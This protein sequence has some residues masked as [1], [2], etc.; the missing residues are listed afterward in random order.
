M[1]RAVLFALAL[2]VCGLALAQ[3]ADVAGWEQARWGMNA[4]QLKAALG[5]ALIEGRT[6]IG[7]PLYT[8]ETKFAGLT[9]PV[10]FTLTPGRGLTEVRVGGAW[11][12]HEREA[13]AAAIEAALFAAYGQPQ[14]NLVSDQRTP[15]GGREVSKVYSWNFP[16][17][18]VSYRRGFTTGGA[19]GVQDLLSIS[20]Q[21]Q[22]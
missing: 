7:L 20:Y 11:V 3:P 10:Q 12:E 4:E 15:Q 2:L 22:R 16:T 8:A 6:Q 14:A 13:E 17:T 21:A 18:V 9:L 19:E 5:P 1:L